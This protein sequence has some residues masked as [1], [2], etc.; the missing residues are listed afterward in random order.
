MTSEPAEEELTLSRAGS[1]ASLSAPQE[2]A[3]ERLIL[4]ISGRKCCTLL[5]SSSPLGSLARMLLASWGWDL[6]LRSLAWKP[7]AT[8]QRRLYFQLSPQAHRTEETDALLWP[9]PRA[10]D[11]KHST[12]GTRGYYH[13][14]DRGYCAEVVRDSVPEAGRLNPDWVEL[15][16]GFP[17]GWTRCE[18][19]PFGKATGKAQRRE[20]RPSDVMLPTA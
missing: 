5:Q 20:S 15:L 3:E 14:R 9:T 4:G 10:D 12:K 19:K 2:S 7:K 11:K 17:P 16:M 13:R 8:K 6:T 1:P 18:A